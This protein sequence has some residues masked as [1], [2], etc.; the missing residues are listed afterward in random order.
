YASR[1]GGAQGQLLAEINSHE[2]ERN[3]DLV[4]AEFRAYQQGVAPAGPGARDLTRFFA[5]IDAQLDQDPGAA[6]VQGND[7]E[8]LTL[9]S[10]R[11]ATLHLGA[12][13]YCWFSDPSKALCLKLAGT[14][15][16][17][18]PLAGMCDSSRCP[19]ATHH[20]CHRP[21]WAD[22]ATT[23]KVFLDTLGAGRRTERTRLQADYDR[24][25]RVVA[26][27]DAATGPTVSQE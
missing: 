15:N 14:P 18:K 17:E 11:A 1:P 13:N 9:F 19:Q 10:R 5:T 25:R 26:E 6:K 22:R 16:A 21:V 23:T 4:L 12:A 3:L 27:I 2:Q 7:R 24:A 20:P 8:I